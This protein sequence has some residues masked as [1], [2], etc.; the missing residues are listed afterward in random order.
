[1]MILIYAFCGFLFFKIFPEFAGYRS[2][3]V[4]GALVMA[5]ASAFI[6]QAATWAAN[7]RVGIWVQSPPVR[8]RDAPTGLG[9]IAMAALAASV[10]STYLVGIGF[11]DGM[12]R[13]AF[14][15]HRADPTLFWAMAALAPLLH[16]VVV[17][18]T[19]RKA[20]KVHA[21]ARQDI[22]VGPTASFRPENHR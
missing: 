6:I 2:N 7:W 14:N 17:A 19:Y 9:W 15:G 1:M 8:G 21:E 12:M 3:T 11:S 20:V 4:V 16:L 18:P 22:E 10:A 5:A 13:S